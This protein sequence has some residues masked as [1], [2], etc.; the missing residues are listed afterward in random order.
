MKTI[1]IVP[2]LFHP[3]SFVWQ[4]RHI[5]CSCRLF[6]RIRIRHC[7]IFRQP[8]TPS[9]LLSLSANSSL[10]MDTP[11]LNGL[12]EQSLAGF[13]PALPIP[14]RKHMDATLSRCCQNGWSHD[15][16]RNIDTIS[17]YK[18]ITCWSIRRGVY[19]AKT[20]MCAYLMIK[21]KKLFFKNWWRQ[22]RCVPAESSCQP[23]WVAMI[24][25]SSYSLW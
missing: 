9:S 8:S 5:G 21:S 6:G 18:L 1:R 25:L 17:F 7:F 16:V 13:S 3:L 22:M 12:V 15:R 11:I 4:C 2:I 20:Y 23:W 14:T 24:D 10:I 19:G